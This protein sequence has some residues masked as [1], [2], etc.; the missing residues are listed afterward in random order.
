MDAT[1]NTALLKD[2]LEANGEEHL[3]NKIVELS[4]H[5]EAE[6]PVIFGWQHVEEFIRAIETARTLAA[7]PGGEPLPAAPLGL[8][9]VVTVQNFKEAVLDYATVPE[10]LGRLNTTCLPCTMAQY[11]NV[12]AR[13]AVLD[14]NLW[15][16][17][18]LDVAM[19]S[20]PIAFVYITR[21]QSR[22]L[23]R[24]MMR[25]PDSLWGN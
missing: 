2:V 18:V 3:Y 13:L 8:P 6:P 20:M 24:V 4:V 1:N 16:R 17:R 15:I 23:D 19:Q 11:G 10:A 9:E 5:V 7:G 22:T 21:A 14:L 25:R 12:A